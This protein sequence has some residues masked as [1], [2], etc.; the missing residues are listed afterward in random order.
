MAGSP[1]ESLRIGLLKCGHIRDEIAAEHG[2]YPELFG[3]LMGSHGVDLVTYDVVHG[4]VPGSVAACDGWLVSGS[5]VSAYDDLPW[6]EAVSEF[7]RSVAEREV[8]L[9][10]ICFGHQLLAQAMGGRVE[11]SDRGW[12]IG[13][14]DYKIIAD[15]PYWPADAPA[16]H[17]LSLVAS[18]Q[19]QVTVVPDGAAV[20]AGTQH[21]PV[22]AFSLGSRA[23]AIQPHPEFD[24]ELSRA[25][26]LA[27]RDQFGHELVDEAL[28]SLHQPT[29]R[30]LVASWMTSF[31]RG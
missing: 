13:I 28:A 5:S 16:A 15:L 9:V 7:L 30:D 22:A 6:I 21:C 12:G 4:P 14:H 27:R 26:T 19:D 29:D 10:A 31:L 23:L 25:L 17:S 11:K 2:D 8:P 20:L 1:S 18:H 3:A 24:A